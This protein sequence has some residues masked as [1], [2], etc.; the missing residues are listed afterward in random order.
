MQGYYDYAYHIARK[1]PNT[2]LS[3]DTISK[4]L[5]S[6]LKQFVTES[7]CCCFIVILCPNSVHLLRLG[8]GLALGLGLVQF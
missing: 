8:L 1:I 4:L 3:K 6:Y 2:L 5:I 7:K